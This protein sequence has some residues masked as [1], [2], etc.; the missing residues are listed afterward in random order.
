MAARGGPRS[1]LRRPAWSGTLD[2]SGLKG[3]VDRGS[4]VVREGT[5]GVK[6]LSE[7]DKADIQK[8]WPRRS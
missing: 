1:R 5:G 6:A 2:A 3:T 8:T 4:M 7:K